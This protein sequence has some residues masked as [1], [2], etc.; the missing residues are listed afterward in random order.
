MSDPKKQ[1]TEGGDSE[2]L[3]TQPHAQP[4]IYIIR[5]PP[6][7]G[8]ST[9]TK[10]LLKRLREGLGRNAAYIEQDYF[11][12]GIAGNAG[13]AAE[14]TIPVINGAVKGAF[15]A[16][17]DV[18]IEGLLTFEKWS[19][20]FEHSNSIAG[21]ANVH[22][23]YLNVPLETT[24][25]RHAGREKALQFGADKIAK[26]F[27]LCSPTGMDNETIIVNDDLDTTVETII[28]LAGLSV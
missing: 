28:S 11:R 13:A 3:Q 2:Q 15:D 27:T 22:I 7:A 4:H 6:A 21:P 17:M 25:E 23:V 10:A 18:V 20:V 8:K 1:R 5:G 16:G 26:W 19:S 12:A 9:T 14:V 24:Q